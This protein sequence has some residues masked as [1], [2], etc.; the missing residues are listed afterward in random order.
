MTSKQMKRF[1]LVAGIS[2]LVLIGAGIP[3]NK[4]FCSP[5]NSI[6]ALASAIDRRDRETV[7]EYVNAPALAES[8]RRYA[9]ETYKREMAKTSTNAIDRLLNPLGDRIVSGLAGVT[10]TPE[11]VVGMLCGDDPAEAMKQGIANSSAETVDTITKDGSP[12]I[13]V[14]GVVAKVLIGWATG[15]VIDEASEKAT[16]NQGEINPNDYVVKAQYETFNRYLITITHR[17]SADPAVGLVFKR[18]GLVTWKFSE[19]RLL[20]QKTH[21]AQPA[22][23]P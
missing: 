5:K 10:Y 8:L 15:Y 9:F 20:P 21:Q 19:V 13:K 7:A 18:H 16:A 12:K 1:A 14:Y 17:N 2:L 22:A 6:L 11:S 3:V 23:T 4:T